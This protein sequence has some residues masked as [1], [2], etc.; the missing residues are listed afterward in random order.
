MSKN[1]DRTI[2]SLRG[3]LRAARHIFF[4]Q[5][6]GRPGYEDPEMAIKYY[7]EKTFIEIL[8][9]IESL[10]LVNTYSI[11]RELYKEAK[12]SKVKMVSM[13]PQWARTNPI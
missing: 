5:V 11:V 13:L 3:S 7:V 2:H 12:E 9:L 4:E 1:I 6:N 8:I 10:G